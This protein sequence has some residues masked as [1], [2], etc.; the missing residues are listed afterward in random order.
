MDP[1]HMKATGVDDWLRH[2]LKLQKKG[3]CPLVIKDPSKPQPDS[4]AGTNKKTKGKRKAKDTEDTSDDE[5]SDATVTTTQKAKGKRKKQDAEND[6]DDANAGQESGVNSGNDQTQAQDDGNV[7]GLPP[8]PHSAAKSMDT[9]YKFLMSLSEDENYRQLIRL[10]HAAKVRAYIVSR[11]L[12]DRILCVPEWPTHRA[13]W[14]GLGDLEVEE[15]LPTT[16]VLS[17]EGSRIALTASYV[18][19]IRS[20]HYRRSFTRILQTTGARCTR[21]RSRYA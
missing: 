9:R 17:G 5:K 19:K 3:K 20:N 8:T 12:T 7:E 15:P 2:W 6:S 21:Y 1:S 18:A 14:T 16:H 13:S 4:P 11:T 10:L